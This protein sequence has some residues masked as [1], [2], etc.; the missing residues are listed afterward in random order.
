MWHRPALLGL[1]IRLLGAERVNMNSIFAA[2]EKRGRRGGR[3]NRRS[4]PI[5]FVISLN[6]VG[7]KKRAAR[8]L[9]PL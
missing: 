9:G 4:A 1:T 2:D 7:Q 6:D 3:T 8:K 5:R